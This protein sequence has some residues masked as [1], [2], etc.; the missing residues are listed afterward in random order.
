MINGKES[1][2]CQQKD[3]KKYKQTTN[4]AFVLAQIFKSRNH[5]PQTCGSKKYP[6][7]YL[8]L[9]QNGLCRKLITFIFASHVPAKSFA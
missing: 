4:P 8:N 9:Y 1:K 2:K 6:E 7:I 3:N 5:R